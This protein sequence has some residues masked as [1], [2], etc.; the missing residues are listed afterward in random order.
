MS[1]NST[2]ISIWKQICALAAIV[3]HS[4]QSTL[5]SPKSSE[6]K[7]KPSDPS[8]CQLIGRGLSRTKI[9]SAFNIMKSQRRK[10]ARVDRRINYC[11]K[12]KSCCYANFVI[13][14][15]KQSKLTACWEKNIIKIIIMHQ[16]I[17]A[18]PIREFLANL[19]YSI[20]TFRWVCR[21]LHMI[22]AEWTT[23]LPA[24]PK[25]TKQRTLP[26]PYD[27]VLTG[28]IYHLLNNSF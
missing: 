18:L 11:F 26:F 3:E 27:T 19:N 9:C 12:I 8:I 25:T 24:M 1:S 23:R 10:Q 4:Y 22:A 6:F 2:C 17:W 28:W 20:L 15:I 21:H 5:W 13:R 16:L 7:S 14:T